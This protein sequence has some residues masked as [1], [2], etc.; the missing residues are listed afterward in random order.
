MTNTGKQCDGPLLPAASLPR[1]QGP[2]LPLCWSCSWT[3]SRS[4]LQPYLKQQPGRL[5]RRS[6]ALTLSW[7]SWKATKCRGSW[8]SRAYK[9]KFF[10]SLNA[11]KLS[12]LKPLSVIN[13]LIQ[14][15]L[16]QS[17]GRLPWGNNGP[18]MWVTSLAHVFKYL[19]W[20]AARVMRAKKRCWWSR[21]VMER[22]KNLWINFLAQ[23]KRTCLLHFPFRPRE[24]N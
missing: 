16:C 15:C 3:P 22:Q 4:Q 21:A 5:S 1:R 7:G 19:L 10:F 18:D 2:P 17:F 23:N 14:W 9:E 6:V 13:K 24:K 12:H 11:F 20:R 8:A